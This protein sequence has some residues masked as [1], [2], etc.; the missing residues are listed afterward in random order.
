MLMDD[1]LDDIAVATV[2]VDTVEAATEGLPGAD[3]S[4]DIAPSR[5]DE[6]TLLSGDDAAAFLDLAVRDPSFE[7]VKEYCESRYD[8]EFDVDSPKVLHHP[9]LPVSH[10]VVFTA[11]PE[12]EGPNGS[13]TLTIAAYVDG[14]TVSQVA[15]FREREDGDQRT[16]IRVILPTESGITERVAVHDHAT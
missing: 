3:I 11:R 15:G 6:L 5:V 2:E 10:S 4:E 9:Y 16:E 8:A 1:P 7:T 13:T 14:E 12:T